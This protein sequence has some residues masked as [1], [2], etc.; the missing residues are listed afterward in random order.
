MRPDRPFTI[1]LEAAI[2]DANILLMGEQLSLAAAETV[3]TWETITRVVKFDDD[4]YGEVEITR[5][6]LSAMVDNFNA[7]IF[8]QDLSIDLSHDF[9]SGAAG[10]IRELKLEGNDLR[11]RIEWTDH[12]REAVTKKGFRYFSADYHPNYK[13]PETGEKHGPLLQGAA[14]TT[15]PRVK[16]L[17]AVDPGPLQLSA[18]AADDRHIAITPSLTRQLTTEIVD[19]KEKY[20]AI[21]LAAIAG[22]KLSEDLVASIKLSWETALGD[23]ADDAT[24]KLITDN[25][26][27]Q[28]GNIHSA[29]QLAAQPAPAGADPGSSP[30]GTAAVQLSADDVAKVVTQQ[31][32]L[33]QQQQ[34]DAARQLA[35]NESAQR[36]R[37]TDALDAHEGFKSIPEGQKQQIYTLGDSITAAHTDASVDALAANAIQLCDQMAVAASLQA[38]GFVGPAGAVTLSE[39]DASA[40]QKMQGQIDDALKRSS[41][42]QLGHIKLKEPEEGSFAAVV[43]AD[44][45]RRNARR[46]GAEAVRL[47]GGEVVI[48]DTDLPVGFQRTVIREALA[49][50]QIFDLVSTQMDPN[51]TATTQ[52]PYEVRD[53][54]NV[55]NQG[56]VY[57]GNEIPSAGVTQLMDTAYINAM[58]VSMNL[59]NEVMH[60]SDRS[61]IDWSAW[62]RNVESNGRL[63]GDLT[64]ARLANEYQRSADT[65]GAVAVSAEAIDAQVD[66]AT[67]TFKTA[68]FPLV[69]P[70]QERDLQGTA[71]GSESNPIVLVLNGTTITPYDGSGSQAS[72][73]YYRVLNYNLGYIQWVNEA[74]V[75]QTP[76]D[77][78]TNTISYSYATNV[79]KFDLDVPGGTTLEKH[80]NGLLQ[81]VG[82][83]K[84]LLMAD[85][86]V[87][88]DFLLMNPVLNDTATNA[89]N[90]T[91]Q[92]RRD[93]ADTTPGGDLE[94]IKGINAW[95]TNAAGIDLGDERIIVGPRGLQGY[96]ISKPWSIGQPFEAVGANG[97]P[98]GKKIAYGE[99]YVGM[100]VPAPVRNRLTSV[101]AYSVT[102]RAAV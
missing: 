38:R 91:A 43:L 79:S 95:G 50:Q 2:S 100:K 41:Q 26:I 61:A 77:T 94:R 12:G 70:H 13:N 49:D 1:Q 73:T 72:G 60:F 51:A 90:F 66:G 25:A 63:M 29:L 18:H 96:T 86:L 84:A 4:Y 76:A 47:A 23:T 40:V 30:G 97:L 20:L 8:G 75:A 54:A 44:F 33:Q 53:L 5:P 102:A 28:A 27:T 21:L 37:F 48:S 71:I 87:K 10:F 67:H 92:A 36:K 15:R 80:L 9:S 98:T 31:L 24:A 46:L 64:A 45:D 62:A 16:N 17:A 65:Y 32:A 68:N 55:I 56:L 83:R 19:M 78:G 14:L 7:N 39:T 52:I 88:P 57:E 58:K 101:I 42:H 93:G 11:G 35:Q 59:S 34:A 22:F 82:A 81:A 69:R 85:R 99:Q 6:M 74:G 3:E 89:E